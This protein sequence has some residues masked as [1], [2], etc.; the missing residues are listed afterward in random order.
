[1]PPDPP[2]SADFHDPLGAI[3][4]CLRSLGVPHVLIGGIA[5]SQL[6]QPRATADIDLLVMLDNDAQIDALQREAGSCGFAPRIRDA[7]PFARQNRVLLLRHAATGIAV[8]L[9]LGSLP[10][11][12]ELVERSAL[13][14]VGDLQLPLPTVEDLI[15]LK[16]V[17]HRERDLQDIRMLVE[18]HP[19]L[20]RQRIRAVVAEFAAALETPGMLRDLEALL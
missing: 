2:G 9:A 4:A 13:H 17:A 12:K 6:S 18:A 16:A 10:F 8:D 11:E 1:M 7:V 14:A 3:L 15:V 20:D 19:G 5:V